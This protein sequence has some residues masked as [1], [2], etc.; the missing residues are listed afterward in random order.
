MPKQ[1]S[2]TS[3][4][5]CPFSTPKFRPTRCAGPDEFYKTFRSPNTAPYS[6]VRTKGF[7]AGTNWSV[8][9]LWL[10]EHSLQGACIAGFKIESY[11]SRIKDELSD[12][13][14]LVRKATKAGALTESEERLALG[15][16]N[17]A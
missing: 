16:L 15:I 6:K 14:K 17:Q 12:L 3:P 1:K 5:A 13:A 9:T 8:F 11:S 10:Y 4:A 2:N 7:Q